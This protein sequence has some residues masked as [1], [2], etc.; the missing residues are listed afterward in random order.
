MCADYLIASYSSSAEDLLVAATR[1]LLLT[2]LGLLFAGK[3]FLGNA[4][5][6]FL[7]FLG[8]RH[9]GILLSNDCLQQI[10]ADIVRLSTLLFVEDDATRER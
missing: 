2:I 9:I 4:G 1:V 6:P 10:F 3:S 8:N 5:Q 7:L